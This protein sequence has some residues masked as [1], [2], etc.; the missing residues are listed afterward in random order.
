MLDD[1]VDVPRVHEQRA[2][3]HLRGAGELREEQRS[4]PA[5][6]Q[7]RLGLA[8]HELVGDE[9]HPVAQRRDHH[10]VRPAVERDERGL[11]DV[12][13]DVLDGRRAGLPEAA[14]DA[15]DEELDL[16]ALRP[17]L[18]A[19]EPRR[20]EHLDHGRRPRAGRILLEEALERVQLVRD[21][22]R[23]VE[24]LDAEDEPLPLVLAVELGQ[25]PRGLGVLEGR[26]EALRVD[27]DRVDADPDRAPV[28]LERVRV[29]VDPEDPE[30]RGAEV[31]CVVADLEADVVG[32]EHAAQELL[33]GREQA[34]HLARG[35]RR[36]QEEP[37]REARIA[38]AQECRHEHQVEVVD[39]HPA[40]RLGVLEDDVR[41]PLV[42]LDVARP[43]LGGDPEP[44]REVVE[45]RP[46]RVV[47][48]A[49]VE[50]LLLAPRRGGP[51]RGCLAGDAAGRAARAR[52]GRR[53]RASRPSSTSPRT[54]CSATAR[55]PE[56]GDTSMPSSDSERRIGRRLLAMTRPW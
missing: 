11:R 13:M 54:A 7:A 10:H 17:V 49:V 34:V 37:D 8:E 4:A 30:H 33:A 26:P 16:V 46:E 47:A 41:E 19:L 22:L 21:P 53:C 38:P 28:D 6:R 50:V 32:P 52:A 23:V 36:V 44:V 5:L 48:D 51:A 9:V 55:P 20:H 25:Q 15:R 27:P 14:V 2:R 1:P 24:P 3:K 42:H 56:L 31:P 43:R 18:R 29:R 39:P 35:E 45:E 40:P 12:A